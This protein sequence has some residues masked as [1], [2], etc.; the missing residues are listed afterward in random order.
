MMV[1][2]FI[3]IRS[4]LVTFVQVEKGVPYSSKLAKQIK[5]LYK[6]FMLFVKIQAQ[7][8]HRK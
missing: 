1:M 4:L 6:K 3:G 5:Y 7:H 8:Q 2:C